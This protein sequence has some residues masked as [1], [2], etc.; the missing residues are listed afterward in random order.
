MPTYRLHIEYDGG[1]FHGW[2]IQPDRPTVQE[3]LQEALATVL[4]EA[5]TVVGSGRTD[6]GVHARGQVA[7][8]ETSDSINTFRL[9][10][11]LNGLTPNGIAILSV[12]EAPAGFHARYDARQRC[13]H[14]QISTKP[15]ALDRHLRWYLRPPPRWELIRQAATDLIGTHNFDSFCI[16]QSDTQNRVCTISRLDI[17]DE[18]R[19]HDFRITVA[20]DRFLHG[21]VRAIVGTLIEIG[22]E[23]RPPDDITRILEARSRSAAGPSA[24]AHGLIL[25]A[26]SYAPTDS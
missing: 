12:D 7:H 6:A 1:P 4:D 23:K 9:Q 8:F 10:R 14:Y 5:P 3:A 16:K 19:P 26:V 18:D 21:M 15:R 22:H 13:Y 11:S 2:Q 24:P 20:A 25:H 17:V